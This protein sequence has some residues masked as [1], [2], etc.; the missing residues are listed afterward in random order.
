MTRLDLSCMG[1]V[2][3]GRLLPV[4]CVDAVLDMTSLHVKHIS[5]LG[6]AMVWQARL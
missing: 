4:L 3:P 6:E 1:V 2:L 5:V